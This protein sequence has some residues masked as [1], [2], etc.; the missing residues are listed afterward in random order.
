MLAAEIPVRAL[1][2]DSSFSSALDVAR[3]AYPW[4]PV[5]FLMLDRY[6]AV[7]AAPRVRV[8]VQQFH[9]D[10]DPVTPTLL[11]E[12]LHAA[13][14]AA[15]PIHRVSGRC[16]V[17]PVTRYEPALEGFLAELTRF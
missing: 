16:H 10:D 5:S 12:R 2:L 4:L 13:L 1:V 7:D 17:P 9:C 3:G 8:P 11:A 6:L 14:P 15:R